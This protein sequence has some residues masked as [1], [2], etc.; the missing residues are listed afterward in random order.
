MQGQTREF[1]L[2]LANAEVI[3]FGNENLLNG[4]YDES[5]AE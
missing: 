5:I 4:D 3:S 2:T 1:A